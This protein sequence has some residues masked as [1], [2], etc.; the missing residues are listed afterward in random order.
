MKQDTGLG[1]VSC[2]VVAN[3]Y[4]LK[5]SIEIMKKRFLNSAV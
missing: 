2:Y 3:I 1:P 4:Y 5:T